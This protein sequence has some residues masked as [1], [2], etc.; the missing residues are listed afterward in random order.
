MFL[1]KCCFSRS[2]CTNPNPNPSTGFNK[3]RL[4][5]DPYSARLS[6]TGGNRATTLANHV[7]QCES[8]RTFMGLSRTKSERTYPEV[9]NHSGIRDCFGSR[10]ARYP[11]HRLRHENQSIF[12]LMI[13][14]ITSITAS[15]PVQFLNT[16]PHSVNQASHSVYC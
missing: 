10:M 16:S 6:A 1:L 3:K 15:R 5:Y 4:T 13:K 8:D 14:S 7:T 9:S 11:Q 2:P 12:N